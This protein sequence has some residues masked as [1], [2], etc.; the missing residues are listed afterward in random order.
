MKPVE[1]FIHFDD[2][3]PARIVFF[4]NYY[5]LAHRAMELSLSQWGLKWDDF[6]KHPGVGFPVRHSEAEYFRPIRPGQPVFVTVYPEKISDSSV[7]FRSEFRE[8]ADLASPLSA[9]V[10]VVHV[11]IDTE[12]LQKTKLPKVL[13]DQ[14]EPFLKPS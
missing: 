5:R 1:L 4:G 6:F 8:G 3:D 11:S 2:A 9:V 14:M 12:T 10:K 13:V 7:T